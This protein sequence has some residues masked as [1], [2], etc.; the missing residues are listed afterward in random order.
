[1][2]KQ[3]QSAQSHIYVG[4]H[5]ISRW[6]VVCKP[7]WGKGSS[8]KSRYSGLKYFRKGKVVSVEFTDHFSCM[9]FSMER[10]LIRLTA[11]NAGDL[12]QSTQCVCY[13]MQEAYTSETITWRSFFHI[14]RKPQQKDIVCCSVLTNTKCS[15]DL[16]AMFAI[17]F[18]PYWC[19]HTPWCRGK[20][21]TI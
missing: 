16:V 6:L 2:I 5:P 1:M 21:G 17:N 19:K 12:V 9:Y 7:G 15:F 11:S 18:Y 8:T 10:Y 13:V 4:V 3:N 14:P 20:H